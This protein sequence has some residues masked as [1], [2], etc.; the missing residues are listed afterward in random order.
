MF[1]TVARPICPKAL[2]AGM[3]STWRL[4]RYADLDPSDDIDQAG[5]ASR[6]ILSRAPSLIQ[7]VKA[8][9]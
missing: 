1:R 4:Y 5:T 6:F 9:P 3:L 7:N 2:D 8:L